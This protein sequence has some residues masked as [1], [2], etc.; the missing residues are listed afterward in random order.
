MLSVVLFPLVTPALLAGVVATRG[1]LGDEPL[2]ETLAWMRILGAYDLVVGAC[3]WF[4][5]GPLVSD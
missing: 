2:V 1:I 5:F 3:G 4:L